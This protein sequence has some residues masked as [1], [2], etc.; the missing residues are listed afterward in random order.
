MKIDV[1]EI[2]TH[3]SIGSAVTAKVVWYCISLEL[4]NWFKICEISFVILDSTLIIRERIVELKFSTL[5]EQ[6]LPDCLEKLNKFNST[7]LIIDL[8]INIHIFFLISCKTT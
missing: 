2:L 1:T 6:L 3:G 8:A 5:V 4:K 7:N